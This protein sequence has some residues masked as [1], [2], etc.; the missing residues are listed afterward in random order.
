MIQDEKRLYDLTAREEAEARAAALEGFQR[1]FDLLNPKAK[2]VEITGRVRTLMNGLAVI[3]RV[4]VGSVPFWVVLVL[5]GANIVSIDKNARAFADAAAHKDWAQVVMIGGILMTE[6]GLLY[7]AF[8]G[9]ADR[10]KRNADRRAFTLIYLVQSLGIV[11]LGGLRFPKI[12]KRG[13]WQVP[14]EHNLPEMQRPAM[15]LILFT[16]ALLGN[17]YT[18][19]FAEAAKLEIAQTVSFGQFFEALSKL[20]A[21]QSAPVY[22]AILLG[23]TAPIAVFLF[24]EELARVSFE[25]DR[26]YTED[27]LAERDQLWRERLLDAWKAVQEEREARELARK[28]RVKNELS[29]DAPTPYILIEQDPEGTPVPLAESVSQRSLPQLSPVDS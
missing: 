15:T 1:E 28:Y 9:R 7:L 4:I 10:L 17:I 27:L 29:P 14:T 16:L 6:F 25:A 26:R 2:N 24:G 13:G 12:G 22:F 3:L 21:S 23:A 11:L 8:A 19:T 20:P 5:M 18:V